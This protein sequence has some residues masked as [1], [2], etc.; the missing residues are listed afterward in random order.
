LKQVFLMVLALFG[1]LLLTL[2]IFGLPVQ[3]SLGR[4]ATGALGGEIGWS[5]T[6]VKMTP[7]LLAGLGM[8]VAWRAGMYNI[9]GEGQY[10]IGGLAG[11]TMAKLMP[12]VPSGVALSLILICTVIGGAVWAWLAAWLQVKRGVQVVISTILLNFVALQSLNG[13][14]QGPLKAT[15]AGALP[16]TQLL[17]KEWM[18]APFSN[19][20]DLH[21]GVFLAW[22]VAA[23]VSIYLYR[24]IGGF[25]LRM[26]GINER[27]MRVAKLAPE[28][29]QMQAMALSG[30]LCGLAG[31]V[32]YMALSGTI[33]A[34]FPQQWGFLAIPVALLGFLDPLG[35]V[36]SAFY[37]G[38]L[39][40]GT[41]Q[42]ARF[43]EGSQT[44]IYVIQG[45]AV[46]GFVAIAE[47]QKRR[48]ELKVVADV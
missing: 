16:Q 9:G 13:M 8:V 23:L 2:V 5:R 37:F 30:G 4:M 40:A 46:L 28:R 6:L 27:V 14:V 3:E 25:K 31:G 11:A 39:F 17:P 32:E 33:D 15:G 47:I 44:M 38:A 35:V 22:V 29:V 21:P 24:T 10:I 42:M 26:V 19:R 7:L 36:L 12:N 20:T 48:A 45:V 43:G 34:G 1:L 41:Q 18:L